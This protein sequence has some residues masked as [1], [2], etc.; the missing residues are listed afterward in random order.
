MSSVFG[1]ALLMAAMTLPYAFAGVTVS[2]ALTRS[3]F[4]ASLVYGVDLLGAALGC[5]AVIGILD[6][7]DG[8]TAI[9]ASGLVAALAAMAFARGATEPERVRLA[10]RPLWRRPIFTVVI[11]GIL[12]PLNNG[13]RFGFK[14]VMVKDNVESELDLRTE[15][16]NWYSRIVAF[17]P[18][19]EAPSCGA[20][21]APWRRQPRG[22]GLS[23]HRRRRGHA[24]APFRRHET[25]DRVPEVRPGESRLPPARHPQVGG[26]WRRRWSRSAVRASTLACR[27][28]PVSS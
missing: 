21:R 15:R 27:I 3:P 6:V 17:G 22:P 26:D 9:V 8:P 28:S 4:P 11:L 24:D 2:L 5:A 19:R 25:V 10:A 20:S 13:A 16:W 12:I 18:F 7:L 23:Q 1:I 14:P